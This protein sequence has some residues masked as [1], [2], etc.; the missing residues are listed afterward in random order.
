MNQDEKRKVE[1]MLMVMGLPGLDD[2]NLQQV[3]ADL[4]SSWPG[5]KNQFFVDLLNECDADTRY[6]MYQAMAPRLRFKPLSFVECETSI[7]MRASELVSQGRMRVEGQSPR[8]IN[9]GNQKDE[10]KASALLRCWCCGKKQKF[11]GETPVDAISKARAKGWEHTIGFD[12]ETCPK[13]VRRGKKPDARKALEI[14][15]NA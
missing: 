7:Q 10:P 14:G 2:P 1:N 11:G 5:D 4:V 8:P 13:C 3:L 15:A 6:D 12:I 9:I